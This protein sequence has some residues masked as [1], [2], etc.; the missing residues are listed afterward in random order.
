MSKRQAGAGEAVQGSVVNA[1]T[2]GSGKSVKPDNP[3]GFGWKCQWLAVP[4]SDTRAVATAIGLD[5]IKTSNWRTGLEAAH[6]LD[7]GSVF[8]TPPIHGWVLAVGWGL[9]GTK[10]MRTRYVREELM[11]S[12]SIRFG[13]AQYYASHRGSG[14]VEWARYIKGREM[15]V[16]AYGDGQ[17]S[18]DRGQPYPEEAG[19]VPT[20]ATSEDEGQYWGPDEDDV[21]RIAAAWS[22]DPSQLDQAGLP[23]SVGVLGVCNSGDREEMF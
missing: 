17:I 23:P 18:H 11:T 2:T 7:A 22:L 10:W 4:S 5:R 15:R 3:V 20:P 13:E 8:V 12:L 9:P 19:L 6:A 21:L 14:A 1:R 16:F